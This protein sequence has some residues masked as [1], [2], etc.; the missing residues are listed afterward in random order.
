M[1]AAYEIV[2]ARR[3]LPAAVVESSDPRAKDCPRVVPEGAKL[4]KVGEMVLGYEHDPKKPRWRKL[5]KQQ[6]RAAKRLGQIGRL[7]SLRH[8]QGICHPRPWDGLTL[9]INALCVRD[10]WVTYDQVKTYTNP[11]DLDEIT[12]EMIETEVRFA[13]TGPAR[14][15]S[16]EEAGWLADLKRDELLDIQKLYDVAL[17]MFPVDEAADQ[18]EKRRKARDR[19]VRA[20]RKREERAAKKL[21]VA[22]S[23]ASDPCAK[24]ATSVPMPL[25][26]MQGDTPAT[27][28]SGEVVKEGRGCREGSV[29]KEARGSQRSQ[30][31]DAINNRDDITVSQIIAVTGLPKQTVKS[32]LTRLVKAGDII[33]TAHGRYGM[34]KAAATA[35]SVPEVRPQ[36]PQAL[37]TT[38]SPLL[39]ASQPESPMAILRRWVAQALQEFPEQMPVGRRVPDRLRSTTTEGAPAGGREPA[40]ELLGPPGMPTSHRWCCKVF[41][42]S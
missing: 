32:W 29:G 38:A 19:L 25:V 9:V 39:T 5:G 14:L 37:S 22:V 42:S 30:V 2:A 23:K 27:F 13:F 11:N 1:T 36:P 28:V 4:L 40:G 6:G 12:P 3:N 35:S 18:R 20:R 15:L 16:N 10:G 31:I 34:L 7:N 24:V 17:E 21:E 33:R 8:S 26:S 41:L